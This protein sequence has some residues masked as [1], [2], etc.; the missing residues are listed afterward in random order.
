M[1]YGRQFRA[2]FLFVALTACAAD[3]SIYEEGRGPFP[4]DYKQKIKAAIESKWPVPRN[5]RIVAIS[6]PN[7]G[8]LLREGTFHAVFGAWL[9]CVRLEGNRKQGAKFGTLYAPYAIGSRDTEF[10]LTDEAQCHDVRFEPWL[11]M[12]DG[13]ET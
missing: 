5:F 2:L 12:L 10:Q 7:D 1:K 11:D 8:Y 6:R 3:T 9:G 13:S 4:A